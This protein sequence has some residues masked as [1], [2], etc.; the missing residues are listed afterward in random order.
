LEGSIKLRLATMTALFFLGT[1]RPGIVICS[2]ILQ[3][4]PAGLPPHEAARQGWRVKG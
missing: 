1:G 3:K 4:V 2:I